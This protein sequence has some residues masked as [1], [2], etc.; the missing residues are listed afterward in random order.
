MKYLHTHLLYVFITGSLLF[1]AC[2]GAVRPAAEVTK[3]TPVT[4]TLARPSRAFTDG[5]SASGQ[6]EAINSASISTRLMGSIT[7]IYVNVGDKVKKG[8]LLVAVSS[9]EIAAKRAQT[10]AQIAGAE[11]DVDNAR[12]DY[13]RFN[14][15]FNR[16]SA[17]ASELDNATLRYRSA[18][19]RLE[20]AQQM[21]REV[22][23]SAAYARLTAP[24]DGI[25]TQKLMDMGSL[26][27][28]GA[29]ILTVEEND[30]LR[31][32]ATIAEADI[33]RIKTGDR[34]DIGIKSTGLTTTGQV[35]QISGSSVS[36]GGQYLVKISLP[37]NVQKDLYAGMY[38]N[39]FI[40]V[41]T[42]PGKETADS[43][44]AATVY[45]PA[46]A[47]VEK[48]QLTGMYTVSNTHTALLRWVR[49]GKRM[50]DK[51]EILSGLSAG[52]AFITGSS[53]KLYNGVP[54]K[55]NE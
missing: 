15:L 8:Q 4:V 41:K 49:T 7:K 20:N 31:V 33:S 17:T 44:A 13:D 34:A 30:L 6:V 12:K 50:G 40:P 1:A 27:T 55:T 28:P 9:E 2:S 24:F 22:D 14:A 32:N 23:A 16:Q 36:T 54:V 19:S 43:S 18:K 37:R 35:T 51:V 46:S 38:T 29:P 5:V 10:D 45:V 42:P 39:V 3:D 25:V 52:E 47:L 53:G 26:A 11:A 48:D 21:R